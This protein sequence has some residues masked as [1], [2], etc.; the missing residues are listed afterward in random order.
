MWFTR[1]RH[2]GQTAGPEIG[3]MSRTPLSE[4]LI[5]TWELTSRT[6]TAA[7]GSVRVDPALGPDPVGLLIYDRSGQ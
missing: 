1:A 3:D 5:G 6:D 7:D 2:E 4:A